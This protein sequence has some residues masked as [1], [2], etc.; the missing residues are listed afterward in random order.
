MAP[1]IKETISGLTGIVI[2]AGDRFKLGDSVVGIPPLHPC[3]KARDFIPYTALPEIAIK[4]LEDY[5][6]DGGLVVKALVRK[7]GTGG[8]ECFDDANVDVGF[9]DEDESSFVGYRLVAWG[10]FFTVYGHGEDY[11]QARAAGIKPPVIRY[12][13]PETK[14]I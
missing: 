9:Y 1:T 12:L 11:Q 13:K 8:G 5:L 6:N 14:A 10:D 3:A 2:R 4:R 7:V